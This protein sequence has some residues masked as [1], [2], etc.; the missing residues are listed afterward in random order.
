MLIK[1]TISKPSTE[2]VV[3]ITVQE[4][5]V[6]R[7]DKPRNSLNIQK[8]E[9][10]MCEPN[11]LPAPTANTINSAEAVPE[12]TNGATTPAAVIPATVAEPTVT[13]SKAVPTHAKTNGCIFHLPQK[14][15]I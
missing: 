4:I 12:L 7:S 11:T 8:P 14:E 9:S 13:R 1:R 2:I 10:L 6:C 3:S 15:A 5:K